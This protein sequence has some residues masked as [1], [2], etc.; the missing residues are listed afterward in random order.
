M[1][2]PFDDLLELIVRLTVEMCDWSKPRVAFAILTLALGVTC[3]TSV[4]I[5]SW[6]DGLLRSPDI[7]FLL[8]TGIVLLATSATLFCYR[9]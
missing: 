7:Y 1:A 9:D 6:N 4:L 2:N 3:L 5:R 8:P